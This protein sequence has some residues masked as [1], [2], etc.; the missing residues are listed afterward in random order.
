MSVNKMSEIVSEKIIKMILSE[1]KYKPNEKLPN[2]KELCSMFG[3]SR[4]VIRESLK[5]LQAQGFL[6]TTQGS[7][8]YVSEN[9]GMLDDPLGLKFQYTEE[10]IELLT[11]WYEARKILECEV[12]KLACLKASDKEL[13]QIKKKYEEFCN[14]DKSNT[15]EM[16]FADRDFHLEI[17]KACHNPIIERC[18]LHL[19]HSFYYNLV[20]STTYVISK[21]LIKEADAHHERMISFLFDRDPD[22][23]AMAVRSHMNHAV[24]ILKIDMEKK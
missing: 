11:E 24:K 23:A 22:G 10:N 2:E 13:N 9:P 20:N 18:V 1:G 17:A 4:Q 15:K 19:L 21:T 12:I 8:S 6:V 14:M 5:T 7:G 16:L 3:V